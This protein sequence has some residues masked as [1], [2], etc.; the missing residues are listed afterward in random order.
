[1]PTNPIALPLP[2]AAAALLAFATVCWYFRQLYG[3][4]KLWIQPARTGQR[5]TTGGKHR[6]TANRAPYRPSP[7][8]HSLAVQHGW[9]I[10]EPAPTETST[11]AEGAPDYLMMPLSEFERRMGVIDPL[12]QRIPGQALAASIADSDTHELAA[13]A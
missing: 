7:V 6:T 11:F 2:V 8:E 1:M 13:V 3:Y 5:R 4:P 12:P 10:E 9:D